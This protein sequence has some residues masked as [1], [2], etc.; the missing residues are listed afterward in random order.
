MQ[1]NDD[2]CAFNL[3]CTNEFGLC[4]W[5]TTSILQHLESNVHL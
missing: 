5:H 3:D 1:F 4:D 2:I